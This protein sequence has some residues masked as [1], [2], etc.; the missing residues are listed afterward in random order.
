MLLI[1]DDK[2][3]QQPIKSATHTGNEHLSKFEIDA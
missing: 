3:P 1:M 2:L